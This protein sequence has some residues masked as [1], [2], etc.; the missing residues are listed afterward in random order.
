MINLN[1]IFVGTLIFSNFVFA[2][3]DICKNNSDRGI[4]NEIRENKSIINSQEYSKKKRL[5]AVA[6]ISRRVG[7]LS[8][9]DNEKLKDSLKQIPLFRSAITGKNIFMILASPCKGQKYI[10]EVGF[11]RNY[12]LDFSEFTFNS[13]EKYNGALYLDKE[14]YPLD[15]NVNM[16]YRMALKSVSHQRLIN[17]QSPRPNTKKR[18]SVNYLCVKANSLNF[19][20][21]NNVNYIFSSLPKG[22][23]VKIM[24]RE[25]ILRGGIE[26]ML[27]QYNNK[28]GYLAK[29]FLGECQ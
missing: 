28:L 2:N 22:T 24:T 15:D 13:V 10:V 29:Q 21:A 23:K 26:S 5:L 14:R 1:K 17:H 3:M 9:N 11:D 12:N 16:K 25:Q 18:D 7:T 8:Q 27:V 6:Q 19:R 4:C 20:D